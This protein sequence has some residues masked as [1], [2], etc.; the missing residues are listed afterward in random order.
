LRGE[1]GLPVA[2]AIKALD[3]VAVTG[4]GSRGGARPD[5]ARPFGPL[6]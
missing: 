1:Y 2:T 5:G 3:T 4:H 6:L